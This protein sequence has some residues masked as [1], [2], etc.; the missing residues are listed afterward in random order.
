MLIS[1]TYFLVVSSQF[2]PHFFIFLRAYDFMF[3]GSFFFSFCSVPNLKNLEKS[4]KTKFGC[5]FFINLNF[6]IMIYV[7]FI[8]QKTI[9]KNSL[10]F[11]HSTKST[12]LIQKNFILLKIKAKINIFF[13]SFSQKLKKIHIF[14]FEINIFFF[15]KIK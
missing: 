15:S 10:T 6:I 2:S 11:R 8:Q 14:V 4:K 12:Q 3:F 7:S 1:A 9:F 13:F 5:F